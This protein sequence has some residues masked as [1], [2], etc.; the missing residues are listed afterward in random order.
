M[1]ASP[2]GAYKPDPTLAGTAMFGFV[3]KYQKGKTTPS[4]HTEFRFR[5][6]DLRFQSSSFE[7]LVVTGGDYAKLKGVGAING[8]GEYKFMIWASDGDPDTF[9]IKIWEEDESGVETVIYDNETDQAI[10][11]G[12]IVIHRK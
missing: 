6:A 3:S 7:W 1:I 9:R 8:T 4:G 5:T 10:T 12:S 11:G 2:L